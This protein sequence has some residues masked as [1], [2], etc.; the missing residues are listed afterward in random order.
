MEI[1]LAILYGHFQNLNLQSNSKVDLSNKYKGP[2]STLF[3]K[4][5]GTPV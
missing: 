1:I 5:S 4:C 2:Q 3:M